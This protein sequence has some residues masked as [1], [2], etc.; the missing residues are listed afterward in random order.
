MFVLLVVD[1]AETP[2]MVGGGGA[3]QYLTGTVNVPT[4]PV[5]VTIGAGAASAG[6]PQVLA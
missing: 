6:A 2:I 5:T 1:Q 3:G 4:S